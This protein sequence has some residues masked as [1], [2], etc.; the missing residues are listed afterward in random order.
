MSLSSP[1]VLITLSIN[2]LESRRNIALLPHWDKNQIIKF[3]RSL[4][5]Q[6]EK[7]TKLSFLG[8]IVRNCS[9]TKDSCR[10]CGFEGKPL[11]YFISINEKFIYYSFP[12]FCKFIIGLK[13]DS[14]HPVLISYFCIR[15]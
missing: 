3:I 8:A 5:D 14:P 11:W 6:N 10:D 2:D 1:S 12:F 7:Q 4:T 9:L 15:T 13:R